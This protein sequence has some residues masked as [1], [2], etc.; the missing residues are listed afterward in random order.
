M[1]VQSLCIS[2]IGPF[3][4]LEFEFDSRVNVFIGPN[5]SGKSTA[6]WALGDTTVYPFTFPRKLLHQ[7]QESYFELRMSETD[8]EPLHGQFP[9]TRGSEHW[10]PESWQ[11]F[12][13]NL[14]KVGYSQFIPALRHSTDF[15]SEG[16]R[17]KQRE[18]PEPRLRIEARNQGDLASSELK[19]RK[20]WGAID[21]H[22]VPDAAVMQ[23]IIELHFRSFLKDQP[24]FRNV[25][26]KICEVASGIT[27][28]FP[29]EFLGTD[30]DEHGFYPRFRTIDGPLPL[31]TLSQGTQSIIQWLAYLIIGYAEYY[32]YPEDLTEHSGVLIIDEIDAHLHP[33][34]Q[35]RI[36]PTLTRHFPNLQIFCSTH[37]PLMIAGLEAGQLQL[38]RRDASGRVTVSRNKEGTVG[39][40]ADE[41]LRHLLD[42]SD[43]TD[44][45]AEER[46][47]R[48]QDLQLRQDL[49]AP[50]VAELE[51]LRHT[52]NQDLV[53]GPMGGQPDHFTEVLRQVVGNA[54]A[55]TP[56]LQ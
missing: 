53:R 1:P 3:V 18:E 46:L 22:L 21:A 50:E 51:E 47:A 34:W 24:V 48:L 30:E 31:N 35:R 26:D 41:I 56:D 19:K 39:W 28:Q 32:G 25:I 13:A 17:S 23:K 54:P 36:I 12:T 9:I 8:S 33:S 55:D 16:P 5:N 40:T 10:P 7:N 2:N 42:I 4:D 43:P 37:S 38:L 20:V 11:A 29:I 45:G 15:R 49:T 14:E 6:L 52:V 27:G 44:I